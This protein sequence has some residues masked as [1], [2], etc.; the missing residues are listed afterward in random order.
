MDVSNINLSSLVDKINITSNNIG[1]AS[2]YPKAATK[3]NTAYS[4]QISA[5]GRLFNI[6]SQLKTSSKAELQEWHNQMMISPIV[7]TKMLGSVGQSHI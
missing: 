2:Q 3:K 5:E 1:L 6:G 4:L 7:E